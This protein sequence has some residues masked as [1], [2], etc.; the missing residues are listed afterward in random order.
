V[1][2]RHIREAEIGDGASLDGER[3]AVPVKSPYRVPSER[4]RFRLRFRATSS[5][6]GCTPAGARGGCAQAVVKTDNG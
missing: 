1:R 4:R 5:T 6:A 2:G 3:A